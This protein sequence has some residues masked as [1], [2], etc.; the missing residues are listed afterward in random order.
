MYFVALQWLWVPQFFQIVDISRGFPKKLFNIFWNYQTEKIPLYIT[1]SVCICIFTTCQNFLIWIVYHQPKTMSF[2]KPWC[3]RNCAHQQHWY[4]SN[5]LLYQSLNF[6]CWVE[7]GGHQNYAQF[8]DRVI[9]LKNNYII[10]N[11]KKCGKFKFLESCY[12]YH[13]LILTYLNC[14]YN[15]KSLNLHLKK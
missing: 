9:A 14:H 7:K 6:H 10:N 13:H 8:S 4:Q 5:Q 15:S 1:Y 12:E 3:N 2:V 11:F